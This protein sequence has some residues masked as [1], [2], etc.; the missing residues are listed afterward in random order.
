MNWIFNVFDK[1]GGGTLDMNELQNIVHG[2]FC[3]AGIEAPED[4]LDARSE[5]VIKDYFQGLMIFSHKN[6]N[7][8]GTSTLNDP[9]QENCS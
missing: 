4:I 7:A 9:N 2:L 6:L 3:M 8:T 5:V 1:D